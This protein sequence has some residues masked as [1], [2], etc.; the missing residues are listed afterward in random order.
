M[1]QL[2]VNRAVFLSR[3]CENLNYLGQDCMD[4]SGVSL[5]SYMIVSCLYKRLGC[6]MFCSD[7]FNPSLNL[8][9]DFSNYIF[10]Q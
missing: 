9:P 3:L 5:L 1:N 2:L 4:G 7:I 8:M 6:L 10:V